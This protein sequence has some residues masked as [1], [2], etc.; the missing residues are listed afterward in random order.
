MLLREMSHL[1]EGAPPSLPPS[2][3]IHPSSPRG[4][5][6]ELTAANLTDRGVRRRAGTAQC[7]E[8]L[9]SVLGKSESDEV[10]ERDFARFM[11]HKKGKARTPASLAARHGA[12]RPP[13]CAPQRCMPRA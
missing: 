12:C 13:P 5:L 3:H 6:C 9:M 4:T 2:H 10:R 1:M 7:Q 11:E 8:E